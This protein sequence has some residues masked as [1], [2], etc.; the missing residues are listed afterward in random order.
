MFT[1]EDP[2]YR[3]NGKKKTKAPSIKNGKV[4]V[5]LLF[6][7]VRV[8]ATVKIPTLNLQLY[9][10]QDASVFNSLLIL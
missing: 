2:L 10:W 4:T 8:F 1:I 6:T 7:S 3:E 9:F 5:H